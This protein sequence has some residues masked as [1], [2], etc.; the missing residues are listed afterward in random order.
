[1]TK[2]APWVGFAAL[3]VS[4]LGLFWFA[5]GDGAA[6]RDR[7]LDASLIGTDGLQIWLTDQEIAVVHSNPRLAPRVQDMALQIIP[8]YDIDL[9]SNANPPK[10]PQEQMLQASQRDLEYWVLLEKL[11]ALPSLVILP[12]W[13]SGF[14]SS[15]V[16]HDSTLIPR[17]GV[18][19]LLRELGLPLSLITR[20]GPQMTQASVALPGQPAR[21][22]ALFHA[23]LFAR[24]H[25]PSGCAETLGIPAGALVIACTSD[26]NVPAA[27]YLSDPDLLNNHGLGLAENAA[28]AV[29]LI[30]AMRADA[31]KPVYLDTSALHLLVTEDQADEARDYNRGWSEL[32]RFFDYPLSVLWAMAAGVLAL[33]GWRG[34]L[35]FGPPRLPPDEAQEQS[36]T[37]SIDAKA[38]LLRLS[39]NDGRMVAEF[40]RARLDALAEASFGA[41]GFSTGTAGHD[42]LFNL[43]ARRDAALASQFRNTC[44]QLIARGPAMPQTE[45]Y[46][47][48]A[49]FRDLLERLPH[50]PDPISKPD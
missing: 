8:L 13:R 27:Q 40:V 25:L 16:A 1:M 2:A 7:R 30:A 29:D 12:K 24:A 4:V 11:Q 33:T 3:I 15:A 18:A 39:G 6:A 35:R 31:S 14:V 37:V 17:V 47:H 10:T 44:A 45:L 19:Q 50:G 23:Q 28:L 49:T 46:Q 43:L 22:L 26:A 48:L 32:A 5:S 41:G 36:K 20:M 34:L 9:F 42:R 38:R 21:E